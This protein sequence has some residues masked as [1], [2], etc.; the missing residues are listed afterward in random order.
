M[1]FRMSFESLVVGLLIAINIVIVLHTYWMV[2][3]QHA[4]DRLEFLYI[5]GK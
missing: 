5:K 1:N 4:V 2:K 3:I